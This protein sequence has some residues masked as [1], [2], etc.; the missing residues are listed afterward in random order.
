MNTP[1]TSTQSIALKK[2]REKKLS[3]LIRQFPDVA[4]AY[5]QL[6]NMEHLNRM[7]SDA[8]SRRWSNM[9]SALTHR[10][11][12]AGEAWELTTMAVSQA[13][14]DRAASLQPLGPQEQPIKTR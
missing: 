3:E 9:M 13:V 2:A 5:Q 4:D 14:K 10:D 11:I 6:G 7:D 12:A 8:A 1:T